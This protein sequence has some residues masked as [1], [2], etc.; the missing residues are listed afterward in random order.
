M[1]NLR[2]K[3]KI[4]DHDK[5]LKTLE[6]DITTG[7]N[8]IKIRERINA[9]KK[10]SELPTIQI[11]RSNIKDFEFQTSSRA[12]NFIHEKLTSEFKNKKGS[13]YFMDNPNRVINQS[14]TDITSNVAMKFSQIIMHFIKNGNIKDFMK[15]AEKSITKC[16]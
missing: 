5:T 12:L 3:F 2:V 16:F 9:F 4:L 11:E 7:G 8:G 13:V 14:I 15:V 6:Y 1:R 10:K